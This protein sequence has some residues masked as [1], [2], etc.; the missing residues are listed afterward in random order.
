M[1]DDEQRSDGEDD[2]PQVDEMKVTQLK[3]ELKA[4][5]LKTTGN[6]VD[7]VARLKASLVLEGQR[8]TEDEE[9][10]DEQ[11]ENDENDDGEHEPTS[12]PKF[13]PTFKDVEESIDTFSGDDD[14]DI[15]LWVREFDDMAKLCE[16]NVIQKTIYAKRLLRGSARLFVKSDGGG[17]SWERM[18]TALKAE[19]AKRVDSR[20]VHKELQRRKKKADE[21][22]HEYCYQMAEIASRAS[23]ETKAVIQ[24]IIDG[25]EDEG[26]R[27][28]VLYGAKT[29][30]ELKDRL[31]IYADMYGKN[32]AGVK[33]SD[34][35]KKS[36]G[37]EGKDAKR[38][39]KRCY[40]CGD[41]N[42]L[43]VS[44]P[45]KGQGT[46]CFG[47]NEYGHIASNCPKKV[48]TEKK[49][50]CNI[51]QAETGKIRKDVIINNVKVNAVI[52]SG[53]D[54]SLIC[55]E[56]C[57]QIGSPVRGNRKI[58]FRGAGSEKN[59]TLGDIRIKVC[60]DMEVYDITMHIVNSGT[61]PCGMLI[62]TD[63]LNHVDVHMRKGVVSI[64]RIADNTTGETPEVYKID[65]IQDSVD[66]DLSHIQDAD[67]KKEVND[68][69]KEYKPRKERD[70]GIKMSKIGRAHV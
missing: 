34:N 42:H 17:K 7:L 27:K 30:R 8:E 2:T 33:V 49:K 61:I 51:V 9:D 5:K 38:V 28:M 26:Y 50:S 3:E 10:E 57:E 12:R 53:S 67:I 24:Y 62:G 68:L 59:T 25:I 14:K 70:V 37:A 16:W 32:K 15:K 40:N 4:R 48:S 18:K 46:K 41:S 31:D 54:L 19:F 21:S 6:K 35:K 63:F 29:I 52:D 36:S 64:S 66:V 39:G 56:I 45:S 23:I 11:E 43:G 1:A 69:I 65:V 55:E 13:I 22:Y 47:C 58:Q 20:A 44:C 60:I